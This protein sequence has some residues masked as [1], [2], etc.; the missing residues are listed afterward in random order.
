MA[1]LRRGAEL[2]LWSDHTAFVRRHR[3]RIVALMVLGLLVGLTWSL[4]QTGTWTST[5]SISLAPVPKYVLPTGAGLAPPEVSIDTDAQLLGSPEVLGA[6]ADVLGVDTGAAR[7]S[8]SVTASP[9]SHVLH[10]GVTAPSAPAASEAANA[11]AA[12]L[13]RV[14]RNALGSLRP[15]QL[16][17]LRLWVAGQEDLLAQEQRDRLVLPA[18]DEDFALVAELRTGLQELE[19]ARISPAE[20]IDPAVPAPRPDYA[21]R[22]V[23]LVSGAMLGLLAGCLLGALIDRRRLYSSTSSAP[24]HTEGSGDLPDAR[25]R[26]EDAHHVV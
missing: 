26:P 11:A 7:D 16:R 6:V 25:T 17:L 20:V 19:E 15:D 3:L 10:V 4:T 22:E 8:L 5:A 14:R 18:T 24:S 21:N 23:P 2:P 1:V 9:N 12:A 13:V